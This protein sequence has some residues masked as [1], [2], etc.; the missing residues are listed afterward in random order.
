M[1]KIPQTQDDLNNQLLHQIQ[2]LKTSSDSYDSGIK[3]EA[4]RLASTIRTLLHDTKSSK[5][6]LGQLD[7]KLK[8][9]YF[10]TAIADTKFGLTGIRTSTDGVNSVTEYIAPLDKLGPKRKENPWVTFP[11][12][13]KQMIVLNDGDSRFTRQDLILSLANQDGGSHV[14]PG[15]NKPYANLSR[16]NSLNVYHLDNPVKGVELASVRQISFELCRSL[17]GRYPDL[18]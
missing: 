2:F 18:F 11:E 8:I 16:N 5:S 7:V 6:L 17:Q 1:E 15:L 10:N 13:W 3:E 9:Y 14:D 4:K 12:W